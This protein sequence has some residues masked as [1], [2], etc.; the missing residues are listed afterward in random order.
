MKQLAI[1]AA[2]V[3]LTTTV[4]AV[5]EYALSTRPAEFLNISVREGQL[6]LLSRNDHR[7]P[8]T[9]QPATAMVLAKRPIEL[10]FC[11]ADFVYAIRVEGHDRA[12]IVLPGIPSI[13]KVTLPHGQW[14]VRIVRG[15]GKLFEDHSETLV[16]DASD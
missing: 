5:S 3:S 2:Y 13:M 9:K 15:C 12:A 16:L 7:L 11:S 10:R 4:V 14:P 1:I 6:Q 8:S